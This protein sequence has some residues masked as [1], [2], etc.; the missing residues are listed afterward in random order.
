MAQKPPRISA[1]QSANERIEEAM[2][3]AKGEGKIRE[4]E[5]QQIDPPK[6]HDRVE[7][8]Q[9]DIM[10]LA[11][12][13]KEVGLL[14]PI[15][16]RQ[17]PSGRYE[18]IAGYRR[19]EAC[20]LLEMTLIP[21]IV[22]RA[23]DKLALL[24]ML[25]EN[26]QREDLNA[27]DTTISMLQLLAVTLRMSNEEMKSFIY[28]IKNAHN[29]KLVLDESEI[30]KAE[31]VSKSL[32]RVGKIDISGF[33]AKMRLLNLP[34]M[35]IE[36]MR[37]NRLPYTHAVEIAK[38]KDEKLMLSLVAKVLK[39]KLSMRDTK[40]LVSSMLSEN[41]ST[42]NRD[43]SNG[44]KGFLGTLKKIHGIKNQILRDQIYQKMREIEELINEDQ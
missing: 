17:L 16:V 3:E 32:A 9:A 22:V 5:I 28:R 30:E 12:N 31:E 29:G 4:I 43:A 7:C 24:M 18:R 34:P 35:L 8:S 26:L 44:L 14:N 41:K 19:I 6:F 10:S 37:L 2:K 21:A 27:Y 38:L 25:S 1:I 23:D 11:N 20:K 36:S 39:E 42:E 40:A 33:I 13:I 15:I